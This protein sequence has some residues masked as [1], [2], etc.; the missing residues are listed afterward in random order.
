VSLNRYDAKRD[1]NE[2]DIVEAFKSFGI[3]VERLNT[4]LDLLL[5][6]DKRN[7]LVEVKM[8]NKKLNKKQVEFTENWKGQFIIIYNVDQAIKLAK[9]IAN[10]AFWVS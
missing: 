1:A 5:G 9:S 8:P 7:Y 6:Y 3:S 2:K 4:P 10:D